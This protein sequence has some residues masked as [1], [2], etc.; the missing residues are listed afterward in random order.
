MSRGSEKT[1]FQRRYTDCL[2]VYEKMLNII[3]HQENANKTNEIS[4]QTFRM[5]IIKRTRN[6]KCW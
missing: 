3:N 1:F 2:Q 6:K 4:L 5:A